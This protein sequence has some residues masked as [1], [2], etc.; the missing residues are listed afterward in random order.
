MTMLR[1]SLLLTGRSLT[2][3]KRVPEKLAD[4]TVMPVV[5]IFTFAYVFGSAI[6][7]PGGGSYHEFL[8]GGMF[9][10]AAFQPLMSLSVGMAEDVRSGIVDRLR[11]LPIS[12]ASFLVGRNLA[13]LAERMIGFVMF[14]LL[15]LIVGWRVHGT[16]AEFV[17]A[18]A[19]VNLLAFS[20][21]WLG[22]WVGLLVRD[23]ES[24]QTLTFMFFFPVMFL[25]GIF[26]PVEGMPAALRTIGEWS[27]LTAA[28][29]ATRQLFHNP[30]APVGDAWPLQHPVATTLIWAAAL[31]AVFAPLAVRRYA[32]MMR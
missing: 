16:V 24:A 18:F 7:V 15:G 14:M 12:R 26:V 23:G 29:T 3:I 25:S 19:L 31:T 1:E 9:A 10:Q 17:A 27:P 30:V 8:I 20:I 21:S 11:A 4:A 32:R 2:H 6:Q 28:A 13:D 22:T 5:F